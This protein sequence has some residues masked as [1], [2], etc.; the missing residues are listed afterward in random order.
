[1]S[2][3][4]PVVSNKYRGKPVY[5][6]VFCRLIQA[7]AER[8]TIF[9]EEEVAAIMG[10]KGKGNYMAKQAGHIL[11]EI[12]EDEHNQ[13][14]PMLSSVAV[15]KTGKNKGIPSHG[16]FTLAVNLGKIRAKSTDKEKR[17]FWLKELEKTYRVWAK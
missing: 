4:H 8:Q 12:S 10:L 9:Y 3:T 13:K 16:F 5:H 17:L 14:R 6:K 11:G 7:A 1:M 2:N 15:S